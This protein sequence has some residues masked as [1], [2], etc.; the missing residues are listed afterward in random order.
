M[1]GLL[2][3][4]K[5]DLLMTW[6]WGGIEMALANCWVPLAPQVHLEEGFGPEES[7][8]WQLLLWIWTQC[9]SLGGKH[10]VTVVPSRTLLELSRES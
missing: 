5:P 7:P 8:E 4:A 9:L 3:H 10:Q 1:S 6:N 2:H